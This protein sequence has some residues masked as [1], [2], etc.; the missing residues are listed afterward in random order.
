MPIAVKVEAKFYN[1]FIMKRTCK[2]CGAE[3]DT[4]K[5]GASSS[6]CCKKCESEAKGKK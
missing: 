6:Y 1:V 3:Y 2:W 5:S 4:M